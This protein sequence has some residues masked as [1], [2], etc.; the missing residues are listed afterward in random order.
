MEEQRK[1]KGN[2]MSFTGIPFVSE[3]NEYKIDVGGSYES[4]LK[5]LPEAANFIFENINNRL[6]LE[7]TRLEIESKHVF[8]EVEL[9][10]FLNENS[11]RIIN[12]ISSNVITWVFNSGQGV[13][14]LNMFLERTKCTIPYRFLSNKENS[15]IFEQK[16]EK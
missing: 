8:S 16:V 4:L 14:V 12:A 6:D 5:T 3:S 10:G 1:K 7:S 13:K 15:L 9:V 11:D 2:G